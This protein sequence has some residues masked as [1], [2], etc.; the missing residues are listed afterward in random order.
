ML[1]ELAG[2]V[3]DGRITP[4]EVVEESLRRIE[5][6]HDTLNAVVA[7][8]ADEAREDAARHPRSGPLAGLPLL[9]KDM[10]RCRGM[11]TTMGS[12]LFAD[13]PPDEVDDIVVGRLREAG[14]IVL[15]RTNTPAFG[16]AAFTTNQVFGA[17]RNPWNPERSPG[18]SSGGS[19]AALAAGLVPLATTSD[20]GGSVRIPASCCGLVGYKPTMGAIGRNVLPRWIGFSTQGATGRTVADVVLEAS[21]TLGPAD[22]DWL[23]VP[24]A[25]VQLEPSRPE[26]VVACPSLRAAVD[27]VIE[28]AFDEALASLAGAG[29]TVERIDAPSDSSVAVDWFLIGSAELAQSLEGVRGQWDSFEPSLLFALHF[30]EAVTISQYLAAT[31]RRHEVA[32]R[33]DAVLAPGT[34]L[35]TPTANVQSWAP[36]GPL[37]STLGELHDPTIAVNTPDLNVTGHPAVSVPLG[38]DEAGV[39]FGMQVVAPRFADGLALGLA[40]ELERLRPWPTVAA[41]YEP[42]PVP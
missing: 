4:A 7:L 1:E 22:G 9:V 32:S 29:I 11:R 23:S 16:H 17:T 14:A 36:E 21:V 10:A 5:A 20:G 26:R 34:V 42:F 41:G 27:P 18:G 13:A 28:T 39:P 2:A 30:G 15:G 19:A 12:P 24:R 37:P 3:R 40:A 33:F 31:R 8:R 25:G 38:R 6:S 35:V